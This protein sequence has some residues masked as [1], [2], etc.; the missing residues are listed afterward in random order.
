[1]FAMARPLN[2]FR[3]E[4]YMGVNEFVEIVEFLDISIHTLYKIMHAERPR[5]TT[6]RR[7]DAKLGVG[8]HPAD[9]AEFAPKGR[10]AD[11]REG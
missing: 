3:E 11:D 6:M 5:L 8:V 10:N 7:I 1:M 2:E 9:V 4:R